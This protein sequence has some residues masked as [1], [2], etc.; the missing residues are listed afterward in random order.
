MY[1]CSKCEENDV[2]KEQKKI[3]INNEQQKRR[4]KNAQKE[5]F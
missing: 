3:Y 1:S 5:T 4:K 2:F